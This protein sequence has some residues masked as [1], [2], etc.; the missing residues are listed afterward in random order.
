MGAAYGGA[1]TK[2]MPGCIGAMQRLTPAQQREWL[3]RKVPELSRPGRVR[4]FE[5]M[6][7]LVPYEKVHAHANGCSYNMDIMGDVHVWA[8]YQFARLVWNEET[9][10]VSNG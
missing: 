10:E 2:I 1:I 9:A 3:C 8:T 7:K 5:F 6:R 4:V